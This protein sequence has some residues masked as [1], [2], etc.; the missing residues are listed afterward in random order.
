MTSGPDRRGKWRPF[1]ADC[2]GSSV[3]FFL[4]FMETLGIM[5]DLNMGEEPYCFHF[6]LSFLSRFNVLV[7][8]LRILFTNL[9]CLL[10]QF[11]Y[12]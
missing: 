9:A 3:S 2:P 12:C 4:P 1:I 7:L 6:L 8:L 5:F 11:I 10:Y